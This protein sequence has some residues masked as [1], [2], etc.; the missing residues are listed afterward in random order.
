MSSPKPAVFHTRFTLLRPPLL[1]ETAAE[2]NGPVHDM[3]HVRHDRIAQR[4]DADP[5]KRGGIRQRSAG[6]TLAI[7]ADRGRR[8]DLLFA[9]GAHVG[10]MLRGK[11]N[12]SL[13]RTKYGND[14]AVDAV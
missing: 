4:S 10:T 8:D 1:P 7:Q 14:S 5:W 2:A 3:L 6:A 11:R 12:G 9:A 13:V